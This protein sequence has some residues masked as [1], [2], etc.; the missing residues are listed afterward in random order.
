MR[1]LSPRELARALGVS[2]SSLK[3]WVDAGKIVAMRTEGGH[4]RIALPEAMRFVRETGAPLAHPELLDLP[5]AVSPLATE[6]EQFLA[7]L[8]R[9]DGDAARAWL[10]G[11]YLSGTS[12]AELADG[13]IRAAMHAL[14]ELW[15]HDERGVFIEH[16]ATEACLHALGGLR[17]TLAESVGGGAALDARAPLALGCAPEDDPYRLP[18][19]LASMVATE[20][21]LRAVN[22]G[23]DTPLAALRHAVAEHRP[24]LIWVSATAR[25]TPARA[26]ALAAWLASMPRGI[27]AL[28][29]G[30]SG[31]L[32]GRAAD[33][34]R[35]IE[36]MVELGMVARGIAQRG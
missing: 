7:H 11:R 29:G 15:T 12:I 33:G 19:Q 27:V 20:A 6:P 2:E 13:P 5:G 30:R 4:R 9:G 10:V 34:V 35:Y 26:N 17:A 8:Q 28:V 3:R 16:R 21:G 22:L 24:R 32:I 23:P 14:G 1:L 25:P 18:T 36:T 31:E